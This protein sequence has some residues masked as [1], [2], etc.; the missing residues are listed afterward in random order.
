M[1]NDTKEILD[2]VMNRTDLD[3]AEIVHRAEAIIYSTKYEDRAP[4]TV[5][6]A[7]WSHLENLKAKRGE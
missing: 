7:L 6:E 4:K 3:Y 5:V 1:L 2:R